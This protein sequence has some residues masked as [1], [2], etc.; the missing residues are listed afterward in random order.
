MEITALTNFL[1]PKTEVASEEDLKSLAWDKSAL[2][3][4]KLRDASIS[5][6]GVDIGSVV[7]VTRKNV[8]S[9]EEEV[10][11]RLVVD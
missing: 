9:G 1:S 5:A 2:P 7:K 4:I 11:Y 10:L 3:F 8:V 6:L